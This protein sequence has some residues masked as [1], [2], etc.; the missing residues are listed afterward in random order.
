MGFVVEEVALR[1][2]FL[3]AVCFH[4][5]QYHSTN[6]LYSSV[7]RCQYCRVTSGSSTR[8]LILSP[9]IHLRKSTELFTNIIHVLYLDISIFSCIPNIRYHALGCYDFPHSLQFNS[10]IL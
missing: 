8:G 2:V 7:I 5:T 1:W 4:P 3:Q 6:A 9:H 10:R